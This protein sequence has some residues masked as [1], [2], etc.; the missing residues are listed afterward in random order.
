MQRTALLADS[1]YLDHRTAPGHPE[2]PERMERLLEV[3]NELWRGAQSSSPSG[4]FR[5][6]PRPATREEILFVHS[7]DHFERVAA[8][9]DREWT[10]Y[11]ADTHASPATFDTALL[12]A[13]GFLEVI[14]AV[15]DGRAG[16]GLALVRP[17]GHHA[18]TSRAMGFCYFNNIAIGAE[19]LRRRGMERILVFD[20]DVHHG[21][22]T[23]EI[24]YDDPG[25][26]YASIHEHPL[27][28]GTGASHETGEGPGRGTTINVPLSSG[29]GDREVLEAYDQKVAPSAAAFDPQ[30][31]LISAGF[32]GHWRDPLASWQMTGHGYAELARRLL[33]LARSHCGGRLAAVL[34]GGYDLDA[35]EECVRAVVH[36]LQGA[37]SPQ[38]TGA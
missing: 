26:L 9:R 28:P 25:I 20:W 35:L 24:F 22:G 4:I 6:E 11:D 15:L 3:A 38:T 1:R 31:V 27:Y 23:Q 19:H 17:P 30:F 13:G 34:E 5:V 2:G 29:T 33:E 7:A 12:A 18:E 36:E 14:D 32:D 21:N 10:V 8:S 16:N 37:R